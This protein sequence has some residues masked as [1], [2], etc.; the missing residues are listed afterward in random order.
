MLI[1]GPRSEVAA[2]GQRD[3]RMTEAAELRADQI[4]GRPDAAHQRVV[5]LGI[6]HAG[7]VDLQRVRAQAAD[8]RTHLIQNFKQQADIGN[9]RNIFN[10]ADASDQKRRGKD[11]DCGVF[12]AADRDNTGKRRA[13]VDHVFFHVIPSRLEYMQ[14]VAF[15]Q[16]Q[17]LHKKEDAETG[18]GA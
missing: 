7:A 15:Q 4:I 10:A 13:A 9:V 3:L 1:N 6:A 16:S 11:C 14:Y 2:A 5:R 17:I 8:L 12:R 18:A